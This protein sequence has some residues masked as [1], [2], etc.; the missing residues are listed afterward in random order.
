MMERPNLFNIEAEKTILGTIIINNDYFGKVND[1]ILSEHFY[2]PVHQKIFDYIA[3]T[4]YK[5]NITADNITLK[6]FFDNDETIKTLGGSAYLTE[7]L[8]RGFGIV[9]VV[10]YA[11]VVK[12]LAIK[13]KI[14][15]ISENIVNETYKNLNQLNSNALIE[16]MESD[17]F[18]LNIKSET[19]KGFTD[20][21]STLKETTKKISI[22][23][24][25]KSGI[26]GI[27]TGLLDL[28]ALTGGFQNSDLIVLAGATSMGKTAF[29]I[30]LLYRVAKNLNEQG[31]S[32]G[33]FSLEMSTEQIAQRIIALESKVS[34]SDFRGGKIEDDQFNKIIQAEQKIQKLP[35]FVDETP[36]L[37]IAAIKTRVRRMVR[38][39]NLGFLVVDYIQLASGTTKNNNSNRAL[40]IAEITRG[41]KAIAKEFNIPVIALAQTSRNID[42][43]DLKRPELSDLRESGSIEQD[44][45]IVMFVHREEYYLYKKKPNDNDPKIDKWQADMEKVRNKVNI[46]IAK[47]RNGEVRDIVLH[48]NGRFGEFDNLADKSYEE[49]I[50]NN[51]K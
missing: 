39:K 43:R 47:N 20:L 38:Q 50:K 11:N 40:E 31:K 5:S 1:I 44:A 35:L 9:D 18:N 33:L 36:G 16:Q 30:N 10:D 51:D 27:P 2:E 14:V 23:M 15:L 17:L 29:A 34:M 46:I 19:S 42:A 7:L 32:A 6:L 45:D 3:N 4:I 25:D 26:T 41:L 22:A 12:D 28:D 13:R 37:S 8:N 48:W 49:M 21:A 24:K